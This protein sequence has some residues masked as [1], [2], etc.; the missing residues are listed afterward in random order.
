MAG[1]NRRILDML[2][3]DLPRASRRPTMAVGRSTSLKVNLSP[4][5]SN[6]KRHGYT[7]SPQ[8]GEYSNSVVIVRVA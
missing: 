6:V 8:C 1:T 7:C 2:F 5:T 4:D 3:C